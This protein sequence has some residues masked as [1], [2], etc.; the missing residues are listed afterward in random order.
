MGETFDGLDRDYFDK[1]YD[2]A[3]RLSKRRWDDYEYEYYIKTPNGLMEDKFAKNTYGRSRKGFEKFKMDHNGNE[4]SQL[5]VDN[6]GKISARPIM[7]KDT[8]ELFGY[9]L[10]FD[11]DN[12]K[13]NEKIEKIFE[14]A[15]KEFCRLL[16][17]KD[18]ETVYNFIF[19]LNEFQFN[20]V[21]KITSILTAY[22][23]YL[24]NPYYRK[25]IDKLKQ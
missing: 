3:N 24:D 7:D 23:E 1:F 13:R 2:E 14:N 9:V 5:F 4:K 19:D 25:V 10:E 8:N 6:A 12:T 15:W 16:E 18:E 22:T 11:G 17:V 20:V 21:D